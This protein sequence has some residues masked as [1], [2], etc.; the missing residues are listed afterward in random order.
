MKNQMKR[1]GKSGAAVGLLLGDDEIESGS[2]TLKRMLAY[3]EQVTVAE[4]GLVAEVK[5]MTSEHS[6]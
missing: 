1:A 5:Q 6:T 3:G 4:S 2:V